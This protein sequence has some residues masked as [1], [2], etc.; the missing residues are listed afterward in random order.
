MPF[1]TAALSVLAGSSPWAASEI[2]ELGRVLA[3]G[4]VG[5]ISTQ[6]MYPI[7]TCQWQNLKLPL[8][9]SERYWGVIK[10]RTQVSYLWNRGLHL[11]SICRSFWAGTRKYYSHSL[12]LLSMFI[13]VC[14]GPVVISICILYQCK[15]KPE[16]SWITLFWT[17]F[18]FCFCNLSSKLFHPANT[19]LNET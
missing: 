1:I 16:H 4:A 3:I 15:W 17:V 10:R 12:I 11:I 9:F 18:Q 6:S 8:N 2:Q 19:R 13:F 7:S 5:Y 14:N